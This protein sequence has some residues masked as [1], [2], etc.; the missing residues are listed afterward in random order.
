MGGKS[1]SKKSPVL[2]FGDTDREICDVKQA[3]GAVN[4]LEQMKRG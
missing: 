2:G 1:D 4:L 3:L